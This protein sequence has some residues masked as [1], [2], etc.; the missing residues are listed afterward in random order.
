MPETIHY[1][2]SD[3]QKF[4]GKDPDPILAFYGGEP[5]IEIPTI[6][7]ILDMVPANHYVINSNGYNIKELGPL[8]HRFDTILLS[9]D[10]RP[11]VTDYYRGTGCTQQILKTVSYL[12]KQQYTGE[13]IARMTVSKKSDIYQEVIYLLSHFPL[14]HWQL[15]A[16]WSNQWELEDFTRWANTRYKQGLQKLIHYFNH[17]LE[18]G[19]IVGIIPFLGIIS[20][21]LHGGSDLPCQSGTGSYTIATDGRILACPIAPEFSWNIRGTMNHFTSISIGEPCLSCD[22]YNEC[23]GRCLFFHKEHLWG[24]DGFEAICDVTKYLIK[25]LALHKQ[26]YNQY[27]KHFSYPTYNN[28]TEII[29]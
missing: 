10:G 18:N 13:L 4:I 6:Q 23:G 28:T 8:I 9:I 3:L 20:R 17:E 11:S 29:P 14:V 19:T 16:V 12:K 22:V 24:T 2:L 21:M 1:P 26:L 25:N 27:K 5:T 7:K 15:D